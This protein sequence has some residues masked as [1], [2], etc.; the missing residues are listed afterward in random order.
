MKLSIHER[1]DSFSFA[2]NEAQALAQGREQIEA[3]VVALDE[4]LPREGRPQPDILKIDAEGWDLDVL[5][6]AEKTAASAEILL[7]E[8]AIMN[9][10]HCSG[11]FS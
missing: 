9:K 2:L 6:G 10:G 3:P 7:M 8:A 4:F 1:D 11:R 5:R